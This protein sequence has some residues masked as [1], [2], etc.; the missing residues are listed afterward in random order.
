MNNQPKKIIIS[1]PFGTHVHLK[2]ATS[3]KGSFTF[4]SRLGKW[5]HIFK[6]LRYTKDGWVNKV[7]L[8]AGGVYN[9]N[10]DDFND[11]SA[12]YSLAGI[13]DDDWDLILIWLQGMGVTDIMVEMN[14]SCPNI[15]KKGIPKRQTMKRYVET[16][17]FVSIKLPPHDSH[18]NRKI[19][20]DAVEEGVTTFHFS[21]TYPTERG[22]LSGNRV[23][24][25]SLL[26]IHLTKVM[27]PQTTI[28]G[29]GGIYTP[30]DVIDYWSHGADYFSLATIW[31]TPWRVPAVIRKIESLQ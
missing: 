25:C 14:I 3:V 7:G 27:F 5:K 2:N 19:I 15:N 22:G 4:M 16:F 28:I 8:R 12:I 17:P 29:G 1:P 6:T 23:K 18:F 30:L 21:N 24:R 26:Q 9:M 31:F 13:D 11:T 20:E 10:P